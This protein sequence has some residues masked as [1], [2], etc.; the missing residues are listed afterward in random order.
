MSM[1]RCTAF[2]ESRNSWFVFIITIDHQCCLS[3]DLLV[4][5][6]QIRSGLHRLQL[7][8]DEALCH[9]LIWFGEAYDEP[10]DFM[11]IVK[12]TAALDTLAKDRQVRGICDLIHRRYPVR[13]MDAPFLDDGTSA[14]QLVKQSCPIRRD[15]ERYD[16][17]NAD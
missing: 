1:Q 11:A 6:T 14:K 8:L 7:I 13:N 3:Q 16:I 15:H 2:R 9:S 5:A 17:L 12:F 10:L 4:G